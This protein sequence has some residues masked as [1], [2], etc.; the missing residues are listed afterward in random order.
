MYLIANMVRCPCCGDETEA[1][2]ACHACDWSQVPGLPHLRERLNRFRRGSGD[3]AYHPT[4]CFVCKR[5]RRQ[6]AHRSWLCPLSVFAAGVEPWQVEAAQE[7]RADAL[8][9]VKAQWRRW[10]A[11]RDWPEIPEAYWHRMATQ[12][13]DPDDEP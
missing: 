12:L 4:G 10:L 8:A 6:V 2:V 5:C 7:G 11:E 13:V 1:L 9:P 3:R